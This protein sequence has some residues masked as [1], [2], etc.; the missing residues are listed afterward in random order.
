MKSTI[1]KISNEHPFRFR[2]LF[3]YLF[4]FTISSWS[5][6]LF[7]YL[8]GRLK[9]S[10]KKE[11]LLSFF[12]FSREREESCLCE[13]QCPS[14]RTRE[15]RPTQ[16]RQSEEEKGTHTQPARSIARV[17]DTRLSRSRH[18]PGDKQ[19][20]RHRSRQRPAQTIKSKETKP[21]T[22]PPPP[23]PPTSHNRKGQRK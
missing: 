11:P 6:P 8:S 5:A 4:I 15:A 14:V 10:K 1:K 20:G 12:R 3:I 18:T 17:N 23:P 2:F 22:P 16:A 21:P 19:S 13:F 9:R 7:G